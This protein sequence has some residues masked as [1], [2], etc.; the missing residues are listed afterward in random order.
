MAIWH[1]LFIFNHLPFPLQYS[2]GTFPF[3]HPLYAWGAQDL[4]FPNFSS[5]LGFLPHMNSQSLWVS[6]L[7]HG[8]PDTQTR[9]SDH[10]ALPTKSAWPN[11]GLLLLHNP[12]FSS[13]L[14]LALCPTPQNLSTMSHVVLSVIC[15]SPFIASLHPTLLGHHFPCHVGCMLCSFLLHCTTQ[16][17]MAQPTLS[18]IY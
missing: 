7:L 5:Q 14:S 4:L 1:W 11:L 12:V 17:H 10:Q 15:L 16:P 13:C 18:V 6:K 9:L 3:I 8:A 2:L